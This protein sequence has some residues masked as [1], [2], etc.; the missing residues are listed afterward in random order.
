MKMNKESKQ[1]KYFRIHSIYQTQLNSCGIVA[2]QIIFYY[3]NK[4]ISLEQINEYVN[5]K[6]LGCSAIDLLNCGKRFGFI[7]AGIKLDFN[8]LRLL[9]EPC[10]LYFKNHH[11]V[12]FQ[13]YN[14]NLFYIFDPIIGKLKMNLYD[15]CKVYTGTALYYHQ[16]KFSKKRKISNYFKIYINDINGFATITI[17][18]LL[19]TYI[20]NI[21]FKNINNVYFVIFW[22]LYIVSFVS[23]RY[24]V[25]KYICKKKILYK[26]KLFSE[27]RFN[28]YILYLYCN[29]Y[30]VDSKML[31]E[32][33]LYIISDFIILCSSI[34]ILLKYHIFS[35]YS[36]NIHLLGLLFFLLLFLIIF[37]VENK[38]MINGKFRKFTNY[39]MV[40]EIIFI[41][42]YFVIYSIKSDTIRGIDNYKLLVPIFLYYASEIMSQLMCLFIFNRKLKEFY[43]NMMQKNME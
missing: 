11:Y 2:L 41:I 35:C 17:M 6:N 40:F 26:S 33:L 32:I 34:A 8:K 16:L 9:N 14:N 21:L 10:I 28:F 7:T 15:F 13:G 43:K 27:R 42:G 3:Y 22:C 38:N 4:F 39:K 29:S 37:L 23:I 24:I 31:D 1:K 30:C 25:I 36:I 18:I 5:V 20:Y 19:F 12:V